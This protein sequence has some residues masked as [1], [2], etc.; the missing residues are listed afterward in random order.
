MHRLL[1]YHADKCTGCLRCETV[2]TFRHKG[3]FGT[4]GSLIKITTDE[5]RMLHAAMFCHHC[6][7]PICIELCP[8]DAITKSEQTG[9]VSIDSEKCIGCGL[10]LE[11]PL[12]GIDMDKETGLA[13]TCDLCNGKP[14][15]VEFC[16]TGALEYLLPE[17]ARRIN[18]A[19]I[20]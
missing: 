10:C 6:Q 5:K 20:T 18:I 11:C 7:R 12:G 9:L 15:C 2:C 1:I 4:S 17:E 8:A 19:Q 14:T 16:P 13:I 3:G